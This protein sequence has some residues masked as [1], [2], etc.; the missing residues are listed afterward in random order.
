[1][2][3]IRE[4]DL[5]VPSIPPEFTQSVCIAE[6]ALSLG[7]WHGDTSELREQLEQI[8]A[9]CPHNT[10]EGDLCLLE[11]VVSHVGIIAIESAA[12]QWWLVDPIDEAK[13]T[14]PEKIAGQSLPKHDRG[15]DCMAYVQQRIAIEVTDQDPVIPVRDGQHVTALVYVQANARL[16]DRDQEFFFRDFP[17]SLSPMDSALIALKKVVAGGISHDKLGVKTTMKVDGDN[18]TVTDEI[19][20]LVLHGNTE[21]PLFVAEGLAIPENRIVLPWSR[22]RTVDTTL[23]EDDIYAFSHRI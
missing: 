2:N 19:D 6:T 9:V 13:T 1:M 7:E 14:Y 8:A 17:T 11:P 3:A 4:V 5:T 16:I 15:A 23:S 10:G 22:K 18:T 20:G 21:K 12:E